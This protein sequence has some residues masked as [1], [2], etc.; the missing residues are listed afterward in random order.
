LVLFGDSDA[1]ILN[2]NLEKL[3]LT[4]RDDL[5]LNVNLSSLRELESVRLE[6]EKDLHD[7]L[8]VCIDHIVILLILVLVV[9]LMLFIVLHDVGECGVQPDLVILCLPLL[10]KHDLLDSSDHIEFHDVFP[11]LP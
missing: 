6:T 10:Y 8:L 7:P 5:Y 3:I 11:K 2:C 1:C 9:H 4:F